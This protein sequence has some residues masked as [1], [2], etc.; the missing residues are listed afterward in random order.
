MFSL[1]NKKIL[2][3]N[4]PQYPHLSGAL[5]SGVT[6]LGHNRIMRPNKQEYLCLIHLLFVFPI[7]VLIGKI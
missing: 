4:Y 2:S 3:L 7:F 5:I 6:G 1:R